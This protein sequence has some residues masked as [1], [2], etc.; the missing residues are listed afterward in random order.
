VDLSIVKRVPIKGRVS[1][2]FRAEM[3]NAM[4]H[5]WFT[6]VSGASAGSFVAPDNFLVTGVGENSNRIVQ[7]VWRVNW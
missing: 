2:D 1:A 5:P 4:N 6:P 3:L 7:L